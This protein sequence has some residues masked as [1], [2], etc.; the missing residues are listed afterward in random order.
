[1]FLEFAHAVRMRHSIQ[2]S[3]HELADG[4][5]LEFSVAIALAIPGDRV[6]VLHLHLHALK[7]RTRE[8]S[9][10]RVSEH[11]SGGDVDAM[12]V[13][14]ADRSYQWVDDFKP[15]RTLRE[16][17]ILE[18]T[19]RALH[20]LRANRRK[21]AHALVV[22]RR[23]ITHCSWSHSWLRWFLDWTQRGRQH[24]VSNVFVLVHDI[25]NLEWKCRRDRRGRYG[26]D[27]RR[28][29]CYMCRERVP[30]GV[31]VSL[32]ARS[33]HAC[34]H[35][36]PVSGSVANANALTVSIPVAHTFAC[37]SASI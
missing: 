20:F 16:H 37:A 33:A 8:P 35:A 5:A 25:S 32:P 27:R 15:G 19:P 4:F 13:D 34:A 14:L 6:R 2:L 28:W 9:E 1:M 17:H 26:M 18:D 12:Q 10:Q 24:R 7:H 23:S 31:R 36:E 11:V 22:G 21:L 3:A 29:S 30:R